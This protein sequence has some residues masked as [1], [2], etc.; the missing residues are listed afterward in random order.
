MLF[1]P[2]RESTKLEGPLIIPYGRNRKIHYKLQG[3]ALISILVRSILHPL[4]RYLGPYQ[5]LLPNTVEDIVEC[6][7]GS[8]WIQR[9]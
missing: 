9:G 3:T 1:Y 8:D 2:L 7:P 6:V 4:L 5:P